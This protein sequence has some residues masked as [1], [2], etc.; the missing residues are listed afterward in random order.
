[1]SFEALLNHTCDIYHL[2]KSGTSPGYQL[3]TAPAFDYPTIPDISGALCHFG[4]TIRSTVEQKEVTNYI[5]TN[6]KLALPIG[7]D[8]RVNDKIVDCSNGQQYTAGILCD[9]RNHHLVVYL[10]KSDKQRFL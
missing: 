10:R 3:P 9:V 6:I 1:M 7:T 5:T 2:I 8:V 4:G